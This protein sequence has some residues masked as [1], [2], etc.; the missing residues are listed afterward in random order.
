MAGLNKVPDGFFKRNDAKERK[1][2]QADTQFL[3]S[4]S[5]LG[6]PLRLCVEQT[7]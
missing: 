5:R 7:S 2:R 4:S 1:G 3:L 6:V